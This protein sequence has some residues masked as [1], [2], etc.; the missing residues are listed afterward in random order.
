LLRQ[1]RKSDARA[2]HALLWACRSDIPL[3]DKFINDEY[4]DWAERYCKKRAVWVVE[5]NGDVAGAMVM[6]A[7]EI[8]YLVVAATHRRKRVAQTLIGQAKRYAVNKRWNGLKA[9][10]NPEN[11][12]VQ[13]L[14]RKEDFYEDSIESDLKWKVFYWKR[15]SAR[16]RC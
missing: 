8:F 16:Q 10:T 5:H 9:K 12:P 15:A 1:A 4:R 7:H 13:R 14:L 11:I 6:L 3:T 2:V